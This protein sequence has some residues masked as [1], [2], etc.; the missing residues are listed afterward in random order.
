MMSAPTVVRRGKAAP[1]AGAAK[2]AKVKQRSDRLNQ[3]KKMPEGRGMKEFNR[4][5]A[6]GSLIES[7]AEKKKRQQ[8]ARMASLADTFKPKG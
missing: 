5:K 6:G 2:A 3:L 7:A 4:I 8:K 1:S